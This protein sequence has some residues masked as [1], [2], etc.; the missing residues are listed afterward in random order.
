MGFFSGLLGSLTGGDVIGAASGLIGGAF[1]QQAGKKAAA[2][3]MAFQQDAYKHRYQWQ[4]QDMRAAGLNPIL[5]YSQGPPGGPGGS[6]YTPQNIGAAAAVGASGGAASAK[7]AKETSWMERQRRASVDNLYEDTM[8]KAMEGKYTNILS[9]NELIKR[10]ILKEE[11]TVRKGEASSARLLKSF[12]D[13]P[14]GAIAK[15]IDLW[16]R[17]I[18]PF[19]ST[20]KNVR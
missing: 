9:H 13:S 1:Q 5:A 17:S 16:G 8:K 7:A 6:S 4:M 2:K 11:L 18:N 10:E 14:Q 19:S 15:T 3:Q 20:L 12:Y